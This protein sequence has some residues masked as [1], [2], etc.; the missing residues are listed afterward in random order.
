[1][2]YY[3]N[4]YGSMMSFGFGS[5]ILGPIMMI[6]FFILI[7]W[8]VIEFTGW[9]PRSRNDYHKHSSGRSA[10]D[11]LDERYAKGEI[12]SKQYNEMKRDLEK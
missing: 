2:D 3:G 9:T 1:M 5:G 4:G 10:L 6:L 12:D 7:V 8:L 11:I